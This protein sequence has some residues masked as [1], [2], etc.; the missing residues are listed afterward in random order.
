MRGVSRLF[1]GLISLQEGLYSVEWS[2]WLVGCC[3]GWLVLSFV[4]LYGCL[5][6]CVIGWLFVVLVIPLISL[7]GWLVCLFLWLVGWLVVALVPLVGCLVWLVC[8]VVGCCV[9]PLVGLLVGCLVWLVCWV[10]GWLFDLVV[11]LVSLVVSLVGWLVGLVVWL[12]GCLCDWL[13]VCCFGYSVSFVGLVGWFGCCVGF[14]GCFFGCLLACFGWF[15]CCVGLVGWVVGWIISRT[16]CVRFQGRASIFI[17]SPPH[18]DFRLYPLTRYGF[19][20]RTK[21]I[22]VTCA[23]TVVMSVCQS[24]TLYCSNCAGHRLQKSLGLDGTNWE[25][26]RGGRRRVCKEISSARTVI[27]VSYLQHVATP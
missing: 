3:F 8:W 4:W 5:V 18:A 23:V 19:Q 27:I 7:V 21:Q 17:S 10:G 14:V 24:T 15:G 16:S 22:A 6:G 9:V 20:P 11:A 26:A 13:V 25:G 12:L 2:G 1:E